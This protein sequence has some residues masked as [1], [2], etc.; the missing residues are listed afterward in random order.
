MPRNMPEIMNEFLRDNPEFQ[1]Q[2][3]QPA[4]NPFEQ[5]GQRRKKTLDGIKDELE[6]TPSPHPVDTPLNGSEVLKAALGDAVPGASTA[7]FLA[8]AIAGRADF[9]G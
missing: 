5:A 7:Q 6:G 4:S 9:A 1:N 3:Q 8:D 2:G